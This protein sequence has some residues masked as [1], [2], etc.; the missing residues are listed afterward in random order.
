MLKQAAVS[1]AK[2]E[3]GGLVA[4]S[5]CTRLGPSSFPGQGGKSVLFWF[6]PLKGMGRVLAKFSPGSALYC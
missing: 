3:D 1:S 6:W 5:Q 2:T 4:A